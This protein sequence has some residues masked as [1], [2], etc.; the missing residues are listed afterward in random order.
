M[1]SGDKQQEG[2]CPHLRHREL[3]LRAPLPS[4]LGV[5]RDAAGGRCRTKEPPVHRGARGEG[6]EEKVDLSFE[7]ILLA[8]FSP[9]HRGCRCFPAPL[10]RLCG[11]VPTCTAAASP[12]GT[13]QLDTAPLGVALGQRKELGKIRKVKSRA[14]GASPGKSF[15]KSARLLVVT[16]PDASSL[17]RCFPLQHERKR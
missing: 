10:C 16:L 8:I 6:R 17:P 14:Q 13:G 1:P 11:P 7:G 4:G 12:H 5:P 3:L 9:F 15:R 2:S